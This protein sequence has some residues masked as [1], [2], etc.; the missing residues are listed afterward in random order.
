MPTFIRPAKVT[1]TEG[2]GLL[3]LAAGVGLVLAGAAGAVALWRAI[4]PAFLTGEQVALWVG[5]GL[6]ALATAGLAVVLR[7]NPGYWYSSPQPRAWRAAHPLGEGQRAEVGAAHARPI[8]SVVPTPEQL[9]A[10]QAARAEVLAW[11]LDQIAAA[12]MSE[13]PY[14]GVRPGT[15]PAIG[16]PR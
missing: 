14:L 4:A 5:G 12:E 3:A 2:G 9:A 15:V 7:R 11:A 16:G 6:L 10:R 13:A 8:L 1:V